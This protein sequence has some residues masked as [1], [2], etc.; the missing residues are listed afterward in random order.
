MLRDV[1]HLW[2]SLDDVDRREFGQSHTP[3]RLL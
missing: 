1:E 2:Q 3:L